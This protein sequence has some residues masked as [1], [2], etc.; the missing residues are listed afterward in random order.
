M[1]RR[2]TYPGWFRVIGYGIVSAAGCQFLGGGAHDVAVGMGVGLLVGVL[3]LA[4]RRFTIPSH[5]FELT[6]S[7]LA[8]AVVTELALAVSTSRCRRRRWPG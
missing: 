4:F 6:G 7:L 3:A 5:V 8:S 1:A 2:P